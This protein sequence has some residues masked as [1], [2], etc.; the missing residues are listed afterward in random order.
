MVNNK[1]V[2]EQKYDAIIIGA[3]IGGLTCANYL[4]KKNKKALLFEQHITPGGYICG[5]YR[6]GYYFDGANNSFS[7]HGSIFPMLSEMGL[8]DKLKFHKHVV[9]QKVRNIGL[10][11]CYSS[12]EEFRQAMRCSFSEEKNIDK[13]LR[14]LESFYGF[15][16]VIK[17][18]K[19]PMLMSGTEK[20]MSGFKFMKLIFKNKKIKDFLTVAKYGSKSSGEF[21]GEFFAEGTE[22]Y[23]FFRSYGNPHQSSV[24][25]GAM[26]SEFIEDKWYPEGGEQHFANVMAEEAQKN[27]IEIKY[28]TP[29]EMIVTDGDRAIGVKA[30]GKEY[31]AKNVVIASDYRTAFLKL[32]DN[33]ALVDSSFIRGL[34]KAKNSESLFT[35]FLGLKCPPEYVKEVLKGGRMNYARC[36]AVKDFTDVDDDGFFDDITISI[37]SPSVMSPSI[38]NEPIS[39]VTIQCLCPNCWHDNWGNGNREEYLRL[40]NM[41]QEK[42]L[43]LFKEALP[44]LVDKID[45]IE[46]ATPKTY[47]RYTLNS[48]G[49]YCAWSWSPHESFFDDLKIH[50]KTP[51]KNLYCCSDWCYKIGGMVSAMI[52]AKRI[53]EKYV[54]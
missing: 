53:A 21:V 51:V 45:Y 27:G 11:F 42:V 32:L 29:V 28:S 44:E 9:L 24:V 6:K 41:I 13:F 1:T 19:N 38:N 12:F 33:K 25:L 4:G 39:S 20:L 31:Y 48:D 49:A 23:K 43:E 47:E 16:S 10:D 30:G 22:A 34:E 52:S 36:S 40:K 54:K 37:F 3:G 14:I 35:T 15:F 8:D 17:E 5:F 46:S 26:I 50:T 18:V 2:M 7:S